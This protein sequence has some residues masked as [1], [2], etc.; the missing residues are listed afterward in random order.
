MFSGMAGLKLKECQLSLL[1]KPLE[2]SECL[3][4]PTFNEGKEGFLTPHS[5]FIKCT[6]LKGFLELQPCCAVECRKTTWALCG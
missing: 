3:L 4:K 6:H 2:G 5:S 1:G